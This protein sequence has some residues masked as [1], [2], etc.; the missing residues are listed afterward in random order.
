VG[1]ADRADR[2]ARQRVRQ[3]GVR[4]AIERLGVQ[5]DVAGPEEGEDRG[6]DTAAIPEENSAQLSVRS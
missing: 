1:K 5:D 3:Q 2:K 4:A 6:R